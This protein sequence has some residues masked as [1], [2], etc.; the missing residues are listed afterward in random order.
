MSQP[1]IFSR[2]I[3]IPLLGQFWRISRYWLFILPFIISDLIG[4]VFFG[5][6]GD[7]F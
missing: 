7:D 1:F 3:E 6:D 4:L 5:D 2:A